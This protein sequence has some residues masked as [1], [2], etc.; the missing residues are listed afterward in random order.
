MKLKG[1]VAFI[2]GGS[3]GIGRGICYAFAKEGASIAFVGL[4]ERKGKNTE[5]ELVEL[6]CEALF[7]QADLS[8]RNNLPV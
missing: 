8:D 6:G 2:T 3:S 4:S 5:K 7:L 1:K